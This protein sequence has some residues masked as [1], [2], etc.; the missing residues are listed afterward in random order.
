[1]AFGGGQLGR[2]SRMDLSV[3]VR[4]CRKAPLMAGPWARPVERSA[5]SIRYTVVE[6]EI[7]PMLGRENA[8]DSITAVEGD[9]S[10]EHLPTRIL[11]GCSRGS[12][13]PGGVGAWQGTHKPGV[14]CGEAVTDGPGD[15]RAS[16]RPERLIMGHARIVCSGIAWLASDRIEEI[17]RLTNEA[18]RFLGHCGGRR[19]GTL[20]PRKERDHHISP[21]WRWRAHGVA[22]ARLRR[23]R[24]GAIIQ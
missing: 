13:P 14:A 3:S 15:R 19:F 7:L 2:L 22:R 16:L 11:V 6:E 21:S 18:A 5:L 23:E 10:A 4:C 17:V 9:R 1:M 12:E 8:L 24:L 20:A